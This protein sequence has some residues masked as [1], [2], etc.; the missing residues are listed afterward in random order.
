MLAARPALVA[1]LIALVVVPYAIAESQSV[2]GT[3]VLKKMSVNNGDRKVTV[4]LKGFDAPCEA[5]YF[6][7][8]L[9]WG[10]KK[11]YQADGGCYQGKWITSLYYYSNRDSGTGGDPVGCERFKLAYDKDKSQYRVFVPRKCLDLAPDKIKVRAEGDNYSSPMPGE[12]GPTKAL[13]RG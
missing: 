3:G 7:V 10:K 13:A 12:A 8:L 4:K 2:Q 11:A 5:H 1:L 9:F 6:R